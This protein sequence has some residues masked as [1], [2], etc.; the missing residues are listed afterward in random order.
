MFVV[1]TT[2]SP[3]S[4]DEPSFHQIQLLRC[5]IVSSSRNKRICRRAVTGRRHNAPSANLGRCPAAVASRHAAAALFAVISVLKEK[6]G[7]LRT[8]IFSRAAQ[9]DSRKA[10]P[11]LSRFFLAGRA[12]NESPERVGACA[13]ATNLVSPVRKLN[14]FPPCA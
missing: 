12:K 1:L 13:H 2:T 10:S 14:P 11:D 3:G 8:T 9:P 7:T 6:T 4:P 5:W